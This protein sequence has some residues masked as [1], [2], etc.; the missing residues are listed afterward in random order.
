MDEQFAFFFKKK[1]G[2]KNPPQNTDAKN[3]RNFADL[4]SCQMGHRFPAKQAKML[5]LSASWKKQTHKQGSRLKLEP[6]A[7]VHRL[8]LAAV[9]REISFFPP[10]PTQFGQH[11]RCLRA[12]L[13]SWILK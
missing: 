11:T 3:I 12:V 9:L 1:K 13:F 10:L 5:V 8:I 4:Q 7:N 2:E 6:T